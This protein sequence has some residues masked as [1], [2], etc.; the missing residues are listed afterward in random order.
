MVPYTVETK[1]R[2][3]AEFILVVLSL[4]ISG[5]ITNIVSIHWMAP[6][7]FGI[8]YSLRWILDKYLWKLTPIKYLVSTPCLAGTWK[9]KLTVIPEGETVRKTT[10]CTLVITQTWTEIDLKLTTD[11]SISST[12]VAGII[13][14]ES[15]TEIRFSYHWKPTV[16]TKE[17]EGG[18]GYNTLILTE[19]NRLQGLFFSNK[20]EVGH[21]DIYLSNS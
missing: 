12:I 6:S 10:K 19:P 15:R 2:L 9:G 8:F 7:T 13:N 1:K 11:W 3:K 14:N 18:T 5:F 17:Q 4:A 16:A 21:I 20:V